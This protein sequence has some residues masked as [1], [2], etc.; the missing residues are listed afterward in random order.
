M[1]QL[2]YNALDLATVIRGAKLGSRE[3]AAFL[4]R[5][6][7]DERPFLQRK[8]R[9]NKHDFILDTNYWLTY[10]SDKPAIDAEFPVIERDIRALGRELFQGSFMGDFADLDL[11][12]K[13]VRLRSLYIDEK[14]DIQI[15]RR[16]LMNKYGF[17]RLTPN[18]VDHLYRCV[19]FYHLQPYVRGTNKCRIEEM[20]PDEMITFK[21]V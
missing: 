8:Y 4:E 13:S 20:E 11:F 19:C 14:G 15:K 18:L 21:V 6:W 5:V 12:F 3:T 1:E 7:A 17:T 16:A 9:G 2:C 10:L